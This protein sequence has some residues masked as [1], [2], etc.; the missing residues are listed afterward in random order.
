MGDGLSS[1]RGPLSLFIL[2]QLVQHIL[3]SSPELAWLSHWMLSSI[4]APRGRSPPERPPPKQPKYY[5]ETS[6][7]F[8]RLI[9]S[10]SL[11]L[12]ARGIAA[13]NLMV[14][15]SGVGDVVTSP[16]SSY[17]VVR[18][19]N[20]EALQEVKEAVCGQSG[21]GTQWCKDP[22]SSVRYPVQSLR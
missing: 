17:I 21:R 6:T 7:E 8:T 3:D 20:F 16:K 12:L 22:V 10:E 18:S 2:I 5:D 11:F 4:F 15:K 1:G 9:P 19:W 14:Q 13:G